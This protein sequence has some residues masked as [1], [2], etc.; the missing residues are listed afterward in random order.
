MEPD[1]WI[2]LGTGIAGLATGAG[3]I[4]YAHRSVGVARE[5]EATARK[6]A[7][8]ALEQEHDRLF[9]P[10]PDSLPART[11]DRQQLFVTLRMPRTY[12]A[13]VLV[14]DGSGG[15]RQVRGLMT[16][17]ANED[18]QVVVEHMPPDRA[19][20]LTRAVVLKLWPPLDGGWTCE[21]GRE[22]ADEHGGGAW[23]EHWL[24]R[25]PV[26]RRAKPAVH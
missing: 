21:C 15:L 16:L 10:Q 12:T 20:M 6:V 4:F 3:A 5:S 9:P 13:R 14:D 11:T 25:A 24:W 8:V 7:R 19:E 2:A 23:P 17:R 26:T 22:S 1:D 18:V